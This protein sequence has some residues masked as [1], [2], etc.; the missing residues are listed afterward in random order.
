MN[1][2][3]NIIWFIFA[4]FWGFISWAFVGILW[5]ISI[6]GIPIGLQC[7]KMAKLAA[8][9]FGKTIVPSNK[10]SSLI[11]N[12]FWMIFGGIELAIVHLIA[13]VILC[14]TII[15]IPFATQSFKLARLSF[16]PF[17]VTIVNGK[18]YKNAP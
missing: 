11:L 8:F 3:G 15:G 7:F 12:I 6:I 16:M 14:I 10:T 13:G 4:G 17:G 9:P 18:N 5:C 2:L 1:C